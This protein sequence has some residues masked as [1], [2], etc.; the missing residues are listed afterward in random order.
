M[1]TSKTTDELRRESTFN[2]LYDLRGAWRMT[3]HYKELLAEEQTR[4]SALAQ[5]VKR[6]IN[7]SGYRR[8]DFDGQIVEIDACGDLVMTTLSSY[9][10]LDAARDPDPADLVDLTLDRPDVAEAVTAGAEEGGAAC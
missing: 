6:R 7:A 9:S 1:A 8:V 3:S 10:D 5:E 2:L 4:V